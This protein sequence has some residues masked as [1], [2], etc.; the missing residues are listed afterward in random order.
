MKKITFALLAMLV[1]LTLASCSKKKEPQQW[2]YK[3]LI[4][5][6]ENMVGGY[7]DF[8]EQRIYIPK[9]EEL[10]TL[11]KAGWELVGVYTRIGTVHPNFGNEKYVTGIQPNVRTTSIFYVFKRPKQEMDEKS[12]E[13]KAPAP[14]ADSTVTDS[15]LMEPSA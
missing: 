7:R 1:A 13:K 14:A 9:D 11:G 15:S 2:E 4:L 6:G 10:D 3:T 8:V 12:K 5:N